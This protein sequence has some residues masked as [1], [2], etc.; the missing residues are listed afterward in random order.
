L[1]I[2]LDDVDLASSAVGKQGDLPGAL[3]PAHHCWAT[4]EGFDKDDCLVGGHAKAIGKCFVG[5]CFAPLLKNGSPLFCQVINQVIGAKRLGRVGKDHWS[6]ACWWG[7]S[8]SW[9][10]VL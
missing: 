9:G 8:G 5:E 10:R 4:V 6:S 2:A 3:I 1:A 7:C